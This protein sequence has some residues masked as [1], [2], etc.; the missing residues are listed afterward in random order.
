[1]DFLGDWVLV[2]DL[3]ATCWLGHPPE[4]QRSEIIEIGLSALDLATNTIVR[5]DTRLIQPTASQIG[6]F[7]TELT[8]ITPEMVEAEGV[9]FEA[10]CAWLREEYAA[11]RRFWVSWGSYDL[12]MMQQECTLRGLPN[13]FS[14]YH[15][16]LKKIYGKLTKAKRDLGLAKVIAAIGLEFDGAHH[17]GGDDAYNTARI[18]QWLVG[19]YTAGVFTQHF[20]KPS[21]ESEPDSP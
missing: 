10:A 17:R 11:E 1:M 12:K 20:P 8:H 13:P 18:A 14:P 16:N 19:T 15:Y 2:V 21:P 9:T 3:E 4:G 5:R 7:C 6:E